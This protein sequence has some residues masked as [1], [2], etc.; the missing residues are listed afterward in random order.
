MAFV[1]AEVSKIYI[2]SVNAIMTVGFF[3][4]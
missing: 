2:T 4:F 1:S 3:Y